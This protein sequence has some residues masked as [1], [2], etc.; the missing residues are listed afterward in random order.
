[1]RAQDAA[2]YLP[3]I[4][5]MLQGESAF[6]VSEGHDPRSLVKIIGG[7][8]G[9]VV[10]IDGHTDMDEAIQESNSVVV[11]PMIDAIVKYDMMCGPVGMITRAA[12][13]REACSSANVEGVI[14]LFDT[15]GGEVSAIEIMERAIL[16]CRVDKPIIGLIQGLCCSAGMWIGSACDELY[17]SQETDIV[18]SIGSMITLANY[19]KRLKAEGIEMHEIYAD[20]STDKNKDYR[21]ALRGNYNPIKQ[22]L[23]NPLNDIFKAAVTRNRPGLNKATTLTG[24]TYIGSNAIKQGLVDGKSNMETL[25]QEI[26][27]GSKFKAL[28]SFAKKKVLTA[29]DISA[30]E[31]ILTKNG[32]KGLKLSAHKPEALLMETTSEEE[33]SIYVYAEEG[34]TDPVGKRC[35]YADDAGE[36]TE[37]NVQDGEHACSDGS[38]VVTSTHDDGMSYV[39]EV[40]SGEAESEENEETP[41]TPAQSKLKAN[42]KKQLARPTSTKKPAKL[43]AESKALVAVM[44]EMIEESN[45]TMAEA[46]EELRAEIGSDGEVVRDANVITGSVPKGKSQFEKT[47]IS[48]TARRQ[49]QINAARAER[50]KKF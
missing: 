14:L 24:R 37:D 34:D 7:V 47:G 2:A 18:G 48:A 10:E 9:S 35:V 49:E 29:K 33:A 3:S 6:D 42:A 22:N 39:D 21:E 4:L 12:Q 15:P 8:T 45:A 50:R 27:F 46:M 13:L 11:I 44:K 23:L 1:M 43:S 38:T 40:V 41:E 19:E 20:D 28:E 32:L 26:M 36:P 30:V 5:K 31:K 17:I 25:I 16:E